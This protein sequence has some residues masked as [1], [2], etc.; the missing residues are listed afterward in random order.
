V[1]R[2]YLR[3]V[4]RERCSERSVAQQTLDAA[5][6]ENVQEM[7]RVLR[8]LFRR[9]SQAAAHTSRDKWLILDV[10]LTGISCGK[11]A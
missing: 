1:T 9:H 3:S 7:Q 8:T 11:Q 5:T 10:D 6:A 2:R 4:G